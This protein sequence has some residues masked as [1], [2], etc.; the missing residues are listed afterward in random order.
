MMQGE[1]HLPAFTRILHIEGEA[2]VK[3]NSDGTVE[4]IGSLKNDD[5]TP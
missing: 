1:F 5:L 3:F 4:D 2:A